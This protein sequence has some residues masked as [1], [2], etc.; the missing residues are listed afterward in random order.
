MNAW[1]TLLYTLTETHLGGAGTAAGGIDLPIA[2]EATTDLPFLPETA[3]KGV[4]REAAERAEAREVDPRRASE[5][6]GW[7]GKDDL[8]GR[9][10]QDKGRPRD[11]GEDAH[12][13]VMT[14]TQGHLLLYPLR[15]LQRPFVYATSSLLLT[16]LVRLTQAFGVPLDTK[17]WVGLLK[18]SS[19]VRTASLDKGPLV[20]E[21]LAFREGEVA[22]DP[23][24]AALGKAI[25]G[26]FGQEERGPTGA[27][28]SQDL[29]VLPDLELLQLLRNA[30]PVRARVKL[31]ERKTTT[32]AGG[33]LWYEEMLPSD[34][35]FWSV[36][37]LGVR[38]K[39][40]LAP[41][42]DSLLQRLRHT[43]IGAGESTGHGRCWWWSAARSRA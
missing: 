18:D 29:V 24:V 25:A 16:R 43:Q 33:N 37:A 34:C 19:T 36:L 38:A 23:A 21:Q 35:L 1:L 32:G 11:D 8:R 17:A 41:T 26:W 39:E 28:V 40:D 5:L 27:R 14:L 31:N 4:V 10:S 9:V 6:L 2:R 30:A 7:V 20:L 12:V 13:G 22:Q 42:V 15:S 3:L